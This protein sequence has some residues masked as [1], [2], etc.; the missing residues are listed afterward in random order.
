MGGALNEI[1][2]FG[3]IVVVVSAGFLL[4]VLAA[5]VSERFALPTPAILLLA[6]AVAA[7]RVP[8]LDGYLSTQTVERIAVVALVVILLD[9]GMHVGARRF[10]TAAVPI[11]VLGLIGTLGTAALTA[12][13][14]HAL[15]DLSWTTAWI[16]GAALAPTDPAVLFSVLGN[17][18][19]RGRSGTILD[20]ES[21]VND[22]VGIA[23]VIGI[24][25]YAM[26][27]GSSVWTVVAE[28]GIELLVGLA[29]GL[30][31]GL[32]LVP[33]IQRVS[34]PRAGF[35]P[36]A[37]LAAA[38]V[39]YGATSVLHGSGFLAV[40]LAGLV[41]GDV[42]APFKVEIERFHT[43]L[44]G[45]AEIVVFVALGLTI[46]LSDVFEG[47]AVVEGL[48]LAA[49]LALVARPVVVL[50]LLA[51]VRLRTAERLFVAWGGLKGAVPIL[52]A[53][54]V[55]LAGFGDAPRVYDLVFVVVAV[56]VIVQGTSIPFVARRLGIPMRP[57][58]PGPWELSV[59]LREEP[60]GV[61]HYVVA[62]GARAVGS[63]IRDLP[64]GEGTWI[65][66]VV[67]DG[68]ARQ[69][70]G[71]FVVRP[72]DEVHVLGRTDQA[73]ALRRLLESR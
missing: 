37:V 66:L 41:I 54:F 1:S 43:S 45:L 14:A 11:T 51:P 68:E 72:G 19:V 26:H 29:V 49:V 39:V 18:E 17:R 69:P 5:K 23:L 53:A 7:D 28:V 33:L 32:A 16:L 4:A 3:T 67:R 55:L 46:D 6:A 15:L 13:L 60:A 12:L 52:L 8:A 56:S 73:S 62:P 38:G 2:E 71:S 27:E 63:T 22:P 58:E 47:D 20:G 30:A 9:G 35:Y 44:A 50:L 34:L 31:G 70:R 24:V 25:E 36:I 65:T 42:R 40:F 48:V 64:L 10:R 57:V 61:A 21:G 59:R